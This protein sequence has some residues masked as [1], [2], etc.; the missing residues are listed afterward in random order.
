M[1]SK[2]KIIQRNS[3]A[4]LLLFITALFCLGD[5]NFGSDV[6]LAQVQQ[7][8]PGAIAGTWE[9]L[10]SVD[11]TANSQPPVTILFLAAGN[12]LT[13]KV[14]V[15]KVDPTANGL[16]TN[17]NLEL[18]LSDLKLSEKSLSFNVNEEGNEMEAELVKLNENELE[19]RWRSVIKGRWKSA[20]SEFAGVI[21]MKRKK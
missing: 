14:I 10:V 18:T 8:N 19:G 17:G 20:R 6:T 12:R 1:N 15:P 7:T 5:G 2:R 16:Q 11:G 4:V 9:L 13:G 21:K 3:R